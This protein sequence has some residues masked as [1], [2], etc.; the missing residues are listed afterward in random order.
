MVSHL[1]TSPIFATESINSL[2]SFPNAISMLKSFHQ[3]TVTCDIAIFVLSIHYLY[4]ILDNTS[5]PTKYTTTITQETPLCY[6]HI[7]YGSDS[8]HTVYT[9]EMNGTMLEHFFFQIE[10]IST[11]KFQKCHH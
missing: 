7:Q 6:S 3:Q 10:K 4:L 8:C 1:F 9:Q 2:F 11:S 5:S